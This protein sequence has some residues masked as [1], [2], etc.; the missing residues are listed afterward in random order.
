MS[1]WIRYAAILL[2]LAF[3]SHVASAQQTLGSINGTVTDSSGG[4]LGNVSVKVK[5]AG[6]NLEVSATTRDD[7]SFQVPA[8]PIGKYSVTFSLTGFNSEVHS[9]I[10]VQGGLTA[11]VNGSLK[12]GSVSTSV[13]VTG[14]PLLNQ[15]D[16]TI[17][18]TLGADLIES[19][20]LGTGSF[21][22]LALLSPGVNADFLTGSGS[23][24]GLGNQNI[25][26][27]GQRDTSNSFIV[28][29]V[30]ANNLFNGKSSSG[31]GDNRSV[32]NT[33]ENFSSI[34]GEIQT[35]TSVYSAIGQALP[36]PPQET[37]EELRVN[38]AMYDASEGGY[39]GAHITMQTKGGTNNLHGEVYEYHQTSSWN[40]APF[41]FNQDPTLRDPN[42]PTHG[43]TVPYLNRNTFGGTLGGPIKKDK[44]FFFGSY[45]G[46]RATDQDSSFS[47]VSTLPGLTNNNRD[48]ASLA[49]LADASFNPLCGTPKHA[50]CLTAGSIN[51]VA[52]NI[53]N[54]K[55]PSGQYF[56]PSETIT[57]P[58]TQTRLGYN[59]FIVGPN[60]TFKAD[61]ANGNIDYNFSARD[62]ISGKYYFQNDP[63]FAPFAVSQVGNFPQQLSAASQVFSLENTTTVSPNAVWTQRF[64]FIR[65]KAFAHTTDEFTAADY[66]TQIFNF[67]N[68]PGISITTPNPNFNNGVRIGPASN[69]ADAGIFQN[70][71]QGSTKYSWSVGRHTLAFGFQWNHTQLNVINKNDSLALLNFSNFSSFL[72]GDLCTPNSF[73]CG[74]TGASTFVNGETNRYF[75]AN[76]VGTYANDT[77]RLKSN[78]TVTLGLRWDW[79]GALTEKHGLLA[80]FYPKDYGYDWGSDSFTGI[81]IVVAG[82]NKEFGTK[83]VS[84]STLTGRQWGFA[85]RIGIAWTPGFAKNLVVRAG[86]GLYYDRGEYV[87][88]LSP[89]AGGGFNGPFGVTVEP[90][91]VVPILAQPGAPF[92]AP[93]GTG[94]PPPAPSSLAE[95]TSLIPNAAQL[96]ANTTP[97]CTA[98]GIANCG[99]LQFAAYDPTNKLPYS[100]N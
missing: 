48:A 57:D 86:Y 95:V 55:S 28:N 38:T 50:A 54:L 61:Q 93:F 70:D 42:G 53:M 60:T 43:N 87:A 29:G 15:T 5:N 11:T 85:P 7:G 49:A 45:Q 20:P 14:T 88:G 33:G 30:Q 10:L 59:A 17:G 26:A 100:E 84:D 78:L 98:N 76:Q 32:L 47:E 23:N 75:R 79:N 66:G 16:T 8:L 9:E 35:S 31:V 39:S 65:E 13:T 44:L 19:M 52:L 41:F 94:A 22:Q 12:A 72:Q 80:N 68:V 69:F 90:P 56:I 25:F 81:G 67:P 82:N 92:S 36:S 27:N 64:G 77:F 51:S 58:A 83:G 24:A 97:Y 89:S 34:G 37:I 21:T 96:I 63:T 91:F 2:V 74:E 71:F 46:Q 18:Y 40:A 99:P 3:Y 6:T 73:F 62:R 4:V 1:R